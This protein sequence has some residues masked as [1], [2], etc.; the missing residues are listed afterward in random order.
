MLL[1][2]SVS[3]HKTIEETAEERFN[4]VLTVPEYSDEIYTYLREA[5]V[6]FVVTYS[7]WHAY[8]FIYWTP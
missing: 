4:R 2:T 7:L 5:E 3:V 8:I 1:D 6:D